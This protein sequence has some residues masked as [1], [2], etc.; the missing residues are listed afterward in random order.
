MPF[1]FDTGGTLDVG[2][3]AYW[4]LDELSGTRFDEKA[5]NDLADNN[6]VGNN[7]GQV[8]NAAQFVRANS[9]YLNIAD[10]AAL[11]TG[12]IDFAFA[13]WVYLDTINPGNDMRILGKGPAA[14]TREY[15]LDFEDSTDK[16][17]F[18]VGGSG[19]ARA[20]SFGA[21]STGTW[22][23]VV[24]EHDS[25]ANTVSIQVNNGTIDSTAFVGG[26]S[27][28]AG[29]FRMGINE[30]TQSFSA[31]GGRIDEAGF[32]KKTL[33][34]Q[35]RTD[36]Y[37]SGNGQ[38]FDL[39]VVQTIVSDTNVEGEV[40]KTIDSDVTV[41]DGVVSET[42]DA[43][44]DV[45]T[46]SPN[47]TITSDTS[48]PGE[49]SQTI[50]A[51]TIVKQVD[52][53]EPIGSASEV[54]LVASPTLTSDTHILA[55]EVELTF[56]KE[57][58]LGTPVGTL[59]API[60]F[61]TVEAGTVEFNPDNSFV[62]FNDKGGV[63]NSFDAKNVTISVLQLDILDELVGSSNGTASQFFTVAFPPVINDVNRITVKVND[64]NW[65]LVSTFTGFSPTDEIY[66]INTTTG[67]VTFGDGTQG[68]V[69]PNGNTIKVSYTPN[70]IH[71]GK[72][73]SEDL[74]VSVQSLTT[75]ANDVTVELEARMPL[76]ITQVQVFHAPVVTAVSGVFLKFDPNRLGTNFF[77]G[78][79]FDDQSGIITLGTSLPNTNDVLVDYTYTIADDAEGD[80]TAIGKLT[81]HVFA[82]P[83]PSNNAKKLNFKIAPPST[84]S[85]SGGTAINFKIRIEYQE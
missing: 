24:C 15:T 55:R 79:S 1:Q 32:W 40:T 20:D 85:P 36:L 41:L 13:C 81:S 82:N 2:L 33:I 21:L 12:D 35:E 52:I 50:D 28:T 18:Q 3:E 70:T 10:N 49:V 53:T 47:Q 63:L 64:V 37:N 78:G 77:S 34:A 46:V 59:S 68:K 39:G 44:T 38:T 31:L 56:F 17:V 57:S 42:I 60:D 43:D 75:I 74:W 14:G 27:D 23:F 67:T 22:Y 7:T 58:D 80:F 71:A 76:G 65:T 8:S 5:S 48:V 84:A 19:L 9:T 54:V 11:S 61:D 29:D 6:S 72:E 69:P 16:F 66:I 73:V 4:K 83:I 30:N 51:D 45:L 26:P 25:V 62:L